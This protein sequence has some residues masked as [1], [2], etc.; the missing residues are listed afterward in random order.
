M[1]L[2]CDFQH[3]FC[4]IKQKYN[5]WAD[6]GMKILKSR[7]FAWSFSSTCSRKICPEPAKAPGGQAQHFK[8]STC[9]SINVL[10]QWDIQHCK[11]QEIR[12]TPIT[13]RT[14]P[15]PCPRNE[16]LIS[17]SFR[18]KQD[19]IVTLRRK[20]LSSEYHLVTWKSLERIS[21]CFVLYD[22]PD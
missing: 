18:G 12:Q 11:V 2:W 21:F 13:S 4:S 1:F 15:W 14:T 3:G 20:Q 8:I 5:Y 10:P 6:Y 22:W 17:G 9:R 16:V 19:V 7:D